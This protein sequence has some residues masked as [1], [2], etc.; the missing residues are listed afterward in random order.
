MV[1]V[2]RLLTSCSLHLVKTFWTRCSGL[3]LSHEEDAGNTSEFYHTLH[4]LLSMSVS[5]LCV[6]DDD[7][8]TKTLKLFKATTT[9]VGEAIIFY[10]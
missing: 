2:C 10:L 8:K 4:L 7:V 6:D 3:R 5:L 1:N 9:I